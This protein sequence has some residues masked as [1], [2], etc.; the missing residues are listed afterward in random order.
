MHQSVVRPRRGLS[1]LPTGL[2]RTQASL[3]KKQWCAYDEFTWSIVVGIP[4]APSRVACL[5]EYFMYYNYLKRLGT[6]QP[7]GF[8]ILLKS[9]YISKNLLIYCWSLIYFEVNFEL[10]LKTFSSTILKTF[11]STIHYDIYMLVLDHIQIKLF[12]VKDLWD[13]H[14]QYCSQRNIRIIF[15][16]DL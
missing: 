4:T 7:A 3:C 2:P 8:G 9:I 12:V 14:C 13:F 15:L 10:I 16:G 5:P 6:R 1:G 11:S